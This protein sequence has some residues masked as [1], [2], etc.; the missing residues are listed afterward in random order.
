MFHRGSSI[1]KL[2]FFSKKAFFTYNFFS[3]LKKG[4]YPALTYQLVRID[5]ETILPCHRHG[6]LSKY[7]RAQLLDE[8]FRR[9]PKLTD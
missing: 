2:H 4:F 1:L 5:I 8:T 3:S 9:K 7:F 6:T